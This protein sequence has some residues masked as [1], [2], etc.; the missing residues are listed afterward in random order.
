MTLKRILIF[1]LVSFFALAMTVTGFFIYVRHCSYDVDAAVEY[2]DEHA[3]KRSVGLCASYVRHAISAGGIPTYFHPPVA[4]MYIDYLPWLGFEKIEA[5]DLS[6]YLPQKGD[7]VVF[8]AVDGHPFG[9][10]AMYDGRRWVSDFKQRSIYVNKAYMGKNA[11]WTLS[12]RL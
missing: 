12:H 5:D 1:L 7:I 4:S 6:T 3:E 8:E 9:H 10:I 2:L 11:K